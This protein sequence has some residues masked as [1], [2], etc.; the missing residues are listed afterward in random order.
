MKDLFEIRNNREHRQDGFHNHPAIPL[1]AMTESEIVRMP[2]CFREAVIG[3]DDHEGGL[4]LNHFLET[5]AVVDVGRDD[6]EPRRVVGCLD[7]IELRP[8]GGSAGAGGSETTGRRMD[9]GGGCSGAET[10]GDWYFT[11]SNYG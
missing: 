7:R 11:Q 2:I 9:T 4:P 8:G 6:G 1:A 10:V 3:K 5:R